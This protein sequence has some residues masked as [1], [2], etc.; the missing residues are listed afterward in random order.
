MR[1]V[2]GRRIPH[3]WTLTTHGNKSRRTRLEIRELRFD[4]RFDDEI[5]STRNL[6]TWGPREA[7]EGAP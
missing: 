4:E 1:E 2:A 6:K 7:D 3:I 5:F